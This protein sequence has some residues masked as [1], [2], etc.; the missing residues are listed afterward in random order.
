MA[1]AN[2]KHTEIGIIPDDWEVK[3]LG[4]VGEVRMCKRIF[5]QQ[6]T[7][8]GDIPFY[9]IGTFGDEPDAFISK[10]MYDEFRAKFNFPKVGDVMFSA[11]GTIGRIVVY[12]GRPAYFQDS[13]IVWIENDEKIVLNSY[14][15]HYYKIIKWA[16]ADGGTIQRLYNEYIRSTEIPLPPLSEQRSI[17]AVLS[18]TDT[19]IATLDKQIEKKQLIK[20][21]AMRELLSPKNDWKEVRLGEIAEI[22]RGQMITANQYVSGNIP[23]IAGGKTPAGFHNVSNR[24]ANTITIS[25]S[26]ANAGFVA[27]Y[28]EPIF[29]SDC[30]TISESENFDVKYIYFLLLS[31]QDE[32]YKMQTGGAQPHIHPKDIEPML[33]SIPNKAKQTEI[34][35]ILSSMDAEISSLERK[36]EK[37]CQIKA[38]MMQE[39]LTGRVRLAEPQQKAAMIELKPKKT[40]N[41]SHNEQINEAVVISFLVHKFGKQQYPLSRFR[42]TKYAYLLHRQ[43]EKATT[44]FQKHAAGPY[45]S[46]NRYKG[47]ESIA[48]K[49]KYISKVANPKS[50]KDAFVVNENI[51]KA[52]AY[53]TEWY[54]ADI[55][56]WIEQFRYYKNDDL[57][58]LTTVDESVRDLQAENEQITVRSIRN[59]I[60]SIPQWEAKL[61]KL[62]FN[63][64]NI[65]KAINQSNQLFG[66]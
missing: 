51:E 30:S 20:Q 43:Y 4:E 10:E 12:D 22:K 57:E 41:I 17:A 5:K 39:L 32:I 9:K 38:G 37:Y 11:S 40:K 33:F 50:G 52:L 3:K 36:R 19:L 47:A 54:G 14:L 26:G 1:T 28:T 65:Q 56:Q 64:I 45:K 18:D 48:L 53:F 61:N 23:V 24:K 25:A 59:Y 49:N 35:A 2:Y 66:G 13:N 21:G 29:A 16:T 27:F 62:C 44:G 55:Q 8:S 31:K 42:Y 46:E 6:T 34:A 58:V 63:D 15:A 60:H 7:T